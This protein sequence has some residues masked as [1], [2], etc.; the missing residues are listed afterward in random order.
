[1]K[2][3]I[4]NNI[5]IFDPTLKVILWCQDN[6]VVDNPM[7]QNLMK[8][9]KESIIRFKHI[10]PTMMLYSKKPNSLV[11]PFGCLY[12]LWPLLKDQCQ[13]I[14]TDFADMK[15]HA[16][17]IS[18]ANKPMNPS[19]TLFDYQED[20]IQALMKARGGVLS[21]GCGSGK[22]ITAIELVHRIGKRFLWLCGTKDLLRQARQDFLD[23]YPN[24][25][26]GTI[27]DGKIDM[28]KDGTISTIQ[29]MVKV[30]PSIYQYDFPVVVTD[31]CHRVAMNTTDMRMYQKVLGT[32]KARYKYG[33]TATPYRS[34]SLTKSIFAILGMNPDGEFKPAYSVS[35]DRINTLTAQFVSVP[36]KTPWDYCFLNADGTFNYPKLVDYLCQNEQR[37]QAIL[38]FAS[39]CAKS[40]RKIAILSARVEHCELLCD[41]LAN[42]GL[43]VKIVVGKTTNSKRK[44]VLEDPSQW[45]VAVSTLPLFKEGLDI[46]ELDTV[47]MVSP[48]KDKSGII[49]SCGRCERKLEGKKQPIFAFIEDKDIPYCKSVVKKAR[50]YIEGRK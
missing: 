6:L 35:R 7:Y 21:S 49:Q 4:S 45:D 12:G 23:V 15:D 50:R 46:K 29:T 36:T 13:S 33:L 38:K 43:R 34:D 14:E 42:A 40:G 37:N 26:I 16:N 32:V 24:M 9:Q 17:D 18:I 30:D 8:R 19:L 25:D 48:I 47:L 39:A 1:M 11:I 28:G 5:E 10:Q 44:S 22:T 20:A 27:T 2:A 31:E 3:V 41:M